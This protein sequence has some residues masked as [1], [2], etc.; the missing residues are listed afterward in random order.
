MNWRSDTFA[1]PGRISGH[2]YT[3]INCAA[4]GTAADWDGCHSY[5]RGS[6]KNVALVIAPG[7]GFV[8]FHWYRRHREGFWGHKPGGPPARIVDHPGRRIIGTALAPAN[9]ARGPP[10]TF[11]GCHY[12][13]TAGRG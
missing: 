11:T 12:S 2:Q 13:P 7:P 10:Q 3:A 1:Q 9:G 8:D 6:N 4:V 5:C